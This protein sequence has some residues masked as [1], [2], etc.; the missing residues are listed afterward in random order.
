MTVKEKKE[1]YTNR[2]YHQE[3]LARTKQNTISFPCTRTY[4]DIIDNDLLKNC[5]VMR[6]YV[7]VAEDIFCPNVDALQGKKTRTKPNAIRTLYQDVPREIMRAH[8]N[9]TLTGVIMFVNRIPFMITRCK[10]IKFGTV[11][12]V[13]STKIPI[14]LLSL[15]PVI[16]IYRQ[17]GF[18]V[19]HLLMDCQFAPMRGTLAEWGI[20][21]NII[22]AHEHVKTRSTN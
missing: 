15:K 14:L 6:S 22:A 1:L 5:P 9:I 11:D 16:A 20:E 2:Q 19:R 3:K 7:I 10:A 21:L 18:I 12:N 17:R 13:S 8:R 4:L